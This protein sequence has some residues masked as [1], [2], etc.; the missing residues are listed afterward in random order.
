LTRGANDVFDKPDGLLC[1][2]PG[3]GYGG[4]VGRTRRESAPWWAPQSKPPAGAPDVLEKPNSIG[5]DPVA[6]HSPDAFRD[7]I[8]SEIARWGK[9]IRDANI[10]VD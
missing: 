10:K 6:P 5:V 7:L 9:V 8:A 1:G 3:A 2:D 4:T